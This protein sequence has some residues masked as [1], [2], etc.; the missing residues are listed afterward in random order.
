MLR[1]VLRYLPLLCI[2]LLLILLQVF[3][4]TQRSSRSQ[5]TGTSGDPPVQT[6]FPLGSTLFGLALPSPQD[7]WAVGGTFALATAHGGVKYAAPVR[8]TILHDE[9]GNWLANS[10]LPQ[11]LFSISMPSVN[12]GWAVG[13][14]GELAHYNGQRW[15]KVSSPT[16]ANLRGV[17]MLSAQEGW[18]VGANGVILH[19]YDQHWTFAMSPT[20]ANLLSISMV[21]T[22]EG[23]AVGG[24]GTLLHYSAGNWQS[25]TSPTQKTLNSVSML[26]AQEGWAVGEQGIILHYHNDTWGGVKFMASSVGVEDRWLTIAM[27]SSRTGWIAGDSHILNYSAELWAEQGFGSDQYNPGSSYLLYAMV[28][29]AP[30][31]GWAVGDNDSIYH[32]SAGKWEPY[33]Q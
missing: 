4:T 32:Y 24:N 18:A 8:G 22:Q 21:S 33:N 10:F 12:D 1:Y 28:M 2:A 29:I 26:S 3:I 25:V 20:H 27:S 31:E 15:L 17:S 9:N 7:G 30:D 23:W 14:A 16:T 5:I 11:P 6:E 13:Y 19:F